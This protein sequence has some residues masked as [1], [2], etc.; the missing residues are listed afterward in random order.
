M[1]RIGISF[2]VWIVC[3]SCASTSNVSIPFSEDAY[4]SSSAY[5]RTV[6]HGESEN[7]NLA[8]RMAIHS[9]QI[10]L[11]SLIQTLVK[12]VNAE[13]SSAFKSAESEGSKSYF[14]KE[15]ISIAQQTMTRLRVIEKKAILRSD[16]LYEIWVIV[17]LPKKDFIDGFERIFSDSKASSLEDKKKRFQ[18]VFDG[19]WAKLVQ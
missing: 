11:T 13:F 19:E 14:Q 10:E 7:E 5:L 3:C 18:Q 2:L 15:E 16:Q 9:A 1:N 4:Q 8:E 17:E 6:S 12:N